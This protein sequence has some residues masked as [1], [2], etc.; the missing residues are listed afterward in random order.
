MDFTKVKR[1]DLIKILRQNK[2]YLPP[3]ILKHS[4]DELVQIIQNASNLNLEC[5]KDFVLVGQNLKKDRPKEPK[6]PRVVQE[7]VKQQKVQLNE[8][9]SDSD[10][11]DSDDEAIPVQKTSRLLQ[12][13]KIEQKLVQPIQQVVQPKPVPQKPVNNKLHENTVR[14]LLKEYTSDVR[15]L[16]LNYDDGAEID[17]YDEQ[18]IIAEYNE[19]RGM[20]ESKIDEIIGTLQTDFTQAFY[21]QISKLLDQSFDKVQR[22][23]GMN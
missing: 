16:L 15:K 10:S 18:N 1:T 22:F 11:S 17:S 4:K 13:R 20:Y 19:T 7:Q 21:D 2:E 9:S 3:D 23:L 5:A 12:R 6:A 8:L 14:Q